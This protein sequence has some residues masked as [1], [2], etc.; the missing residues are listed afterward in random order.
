MKKGALLLAIAAIT[1]GL[2]GCTAT[3]ADSPDN[4]QPP[5]SAE[6]QA[7]EFS[8][9]YKDDLKQAWVESNSDF[10]REVLADQIV[11]D[12]EWAEVVSAM[13]KCFTENGL[14]FKGFDDGGGYSLGPASISSDEINDIQLTCEKRSGES[15]LNF[16]RYAATKNPDRIPAEQALT[17]CL[18]KHG[19]V[20]PDYTPE[21]FIEDSPGMNFPFKDEDKGEEIFKQCNMDPFA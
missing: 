8:G 2:A 1:I 11:S 15:W 7:P 3:T 9:P 19:A 14:S 13:D 10:V 12:Q 18:I 6:V 20:A 17:A 4:S 21:Q 5:K 16:F